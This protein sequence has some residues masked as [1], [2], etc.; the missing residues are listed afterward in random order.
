MEQKVERPH[1]GKEIDHGALA[2]ENAPAAIQRNED[3]VPENV[4]AGHAHG[5]HAKVHQDEADAGKENP[6]TRG[7]PLA[8]KPSQSGR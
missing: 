6:A 8:H 5:Q 2:V 1:L 4:H 7:E 3:V